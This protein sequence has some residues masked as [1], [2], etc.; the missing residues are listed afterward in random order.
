LSAPTDGRSRG[1]RFD[2]CRCRR[3]ARQRALAH[4]EPSRPTPS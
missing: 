4:R 3:R 2:S 1:R